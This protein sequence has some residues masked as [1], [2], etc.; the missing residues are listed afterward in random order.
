MSL[1][2]QN[3]QTPN[4]THLAFVAVDRFLG[5]DTVRKECFLET[6]LEEHLEPK[7][8]RKQLRNEQLHNLHSLSYIMES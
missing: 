8:G 5:S 1:Y 3:T 7:G 4:L 6:A 2:E